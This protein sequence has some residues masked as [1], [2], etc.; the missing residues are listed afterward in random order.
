[1]SA[2][3]SKFTRRQECLIAALLSEPTHAAAAAKAGISEA[4]AQRWLRDERFQSEYRA[5]RRSVMDSAIARLQRA[6]GKA[7]ETLEKNLT[8]RSPAARNTAAKLILEHAIRGVEL[9]E[10]LEKIDDL[11]AEIERVKNECGP[12]TPPTGSTE[13][14]PEQG[15][16]QSTT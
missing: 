15:G 4:T 16:E 5:A 7:I 13:R 2:G 14:H 9:T 6:S 8:C 10:L 3:G 12:N 1:M 11:A